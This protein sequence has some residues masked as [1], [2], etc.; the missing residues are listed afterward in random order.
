MADA[1]CR[2][3]APHR[4]L[5]HRSTS[6][7]TQARRAH[8]VCG[9]ALSTG[10]LIASLDPAVSRRIIDHTARLRAAKSA[11]LN[12]WMPRH[13][14]RQ[15]RFE[16][17]IRRVVRLRIPTR[18]L[19]DPAGRSST[20][21]TG[22]ARPRSSSTNRAR[23]RASRSASPRLRLTRCTGSWLSIG[24]RPET[25]MSRGVRRFRSVLSGNCEPAAGHREH[26]WSARRLCPAGARR[27]V[28]RLRGRSALSDAEGA[29][30]Q[31]HRLYCSAKRR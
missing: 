5:G 27:A 15:C 16:A 20:N 7:P 28:P 14:R 3:R 25:R 4:A 6:W 19:P 18:A 2:H 23:M 26:M 13:R 21:V 11:G 8:S 30:L 12:D 24:T 29:S 31:I 9:L 1:S 22:R 17:T 10:M